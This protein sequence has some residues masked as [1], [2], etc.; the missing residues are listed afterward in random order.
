MDLEFKETDKVY[1][2]ISSMKGVVRFG[3]NEKLSPH[4]VCLY[5][6]LQS[7][8]NVSYEFYFPSALASVNPVFHA[9]ILKKGI[10]DSESIPQI[11]G[12]GVKDNLSYEEV[13]VQILY[14][15]VTKLMNKEVVYVMVLWKNHLVEGVTWEA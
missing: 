6:I 13:L 5:E 12:L 3:K 1:L 14:R 15:Q 11:D 10:G 7:D 9:S 2:K 4:Y 8:C